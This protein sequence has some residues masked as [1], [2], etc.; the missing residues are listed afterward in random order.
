MLAVHAT[1]VRKQ[2]CLSA[3]VCHFLTMGPAADEV[4]MSV[5]ILTASGAS[6]VFHMFPLA[7]QCTETCSIVCTCA[8]GEMPDFS[9]PD[10]EAEYTGDP[11]NKTDQ[12][13]HRKHLVQLELQAQA[14]KVCACPNPAT[15]V[16]FADCIL[17]SYLEAFQLHQ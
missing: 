3:P 4:C 1:R 8:A 13:S 11:A 12:V 10:A 17:F 15:S 2:C 5:H 7:A 14:K 16:G 6:D 9:I